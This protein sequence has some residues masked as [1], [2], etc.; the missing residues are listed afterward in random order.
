MRE[1]RIMMCEW[2]N[3]D[4]CYFK[5]VNFDNKKPV[6]SFDYDDTLC[7]KF[8]SNIISGVENSLLNLL[9][10]YNICVFTNQLGID[11]AKTTHKEVQSRLDDFTKKLLD[12]SVNHSI[13]VNIQLFY[14]CKDDKYRKPMT[15]MFDLM[16]SLLNPINVEYYCGDA[17]GR[18]G[19]FSRSDLYFANNCNILFKTPE[20][21]FTDSKPALNLCNNILKSFEL[22]KDDKWINGKLDN[23]RN[24]I[25]FID[26]SYIDN[27]YKKFT[28]KTLVILVGPQASGKSTIASYLSSKYNYGIVNRDT[29]K[30]KAAMKKVFKKYESTDS[31]NGIIIDNTSNTK[32]SR[33][34]WIDLLKES[35]RWKVLFIY[36]DI[37][38]VLSIHL[39]KYRQYI[40]GIK[41]PS[42]A[43]HSFYKNLEIPTEDEG[44]DIIILPN[45]V[46]RFKFNQKMRFS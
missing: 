7:Q 32:T 22:Y 34:E 5:I 8:T 37:E 36:I 42:V 41:I 1:E 10:E 6:I 19:D 16:I 39:T 30:T 38:K 25:D 9:K 35:E 28:Q 13:T 24:I 17:A 23:N 31:I 12:E 44:G 20:E 18:K 11:K 43:I 4:S 21:V 33:K 3:K 14:S 45:P 40:Q 29:E 27:I 46:N 15:G 2:N 26:E